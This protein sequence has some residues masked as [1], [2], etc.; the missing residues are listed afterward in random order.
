[1]QPGGGIFLICVG[2]GLVYGALLQG[3]AILLGLQIGFCAGVVGIIAAIITAKGLFGRPTALHRFVV[4]AAIALELAAFAILARSGFLSGDQTATKW[5]V[6]LLIVALHFI[7]MRW[8]HGPLML[9]LALT[10]I[11]WIGLAYLSHFSLPALIAGDG[12]L[13]IVFGIV[14]AAPLLESI[15]VRYLP[16]SIIE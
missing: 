9:W 1:M 16:A 6:A 8:S 13:K 12:L 11:L 14:M 10:S 3:D 15:R 4:L 5:S 2:I 7:V